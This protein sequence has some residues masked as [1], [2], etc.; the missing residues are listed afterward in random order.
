MKRTILI[1]SVLC[2]FGVQGGTTYYLNRNASDFSVAAGYTMDEAGTI[3]ATSVPTSEDEVILPAGTVSIDASSA[4]FAKLSG[5]KRV[6]PGEGAV[7]EITVAEND[8]KTFNAPVNYNGES[9]SY[10]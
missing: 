8:E 2:M 7:L 1:A 3:Q 4:S 6:R 9:V 10:D 5:V